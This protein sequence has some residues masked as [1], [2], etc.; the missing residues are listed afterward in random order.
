[1]ADLMVEREAKLPE[2]MLD[3]RRKL[4]DTQMY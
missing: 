1:M 4:K 2:W 3:L